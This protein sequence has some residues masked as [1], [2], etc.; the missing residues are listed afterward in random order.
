M[1][2]SRGHNEISKHISIF[3]NQFEFLSAFFYSI[4]SPLLSLPPL[5]SW[6]CVTCVRVCT[7]G[8]YFIVTF[9]LMKT[10]KKFFFLNFFHGFH[11]HLLMTTL[12]FNFS[13]FDS[14]IGVDRADMF[15]TLTFDVSCNSTSLL[16]LSLSVCLSVAFLL[17]LLSRG[18][19]LS[20]TLLGV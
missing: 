12:P 14:L 3:K 2:S 13:L 17:D 19:F 6:S 1:I 4:N 9:F 18:R 5:F 16:V 10:W 11:R 15:W 20:S 8:V 7:M